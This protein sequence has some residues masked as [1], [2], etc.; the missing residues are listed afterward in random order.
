M[1]ITITEKAQKTAE[2]ERKIAARPTPKQGVISVPRL[3]LAALTREELLLFLA[4]Q[5]FD[6][7]PIHRLMYKVAFWHGLRVS[8][9][10]S[11]TKENIRDGNITVQRLKGSLA[12]VQPFVA[13]PN[14]LLNEADDLREMYSQLQAGERL[15]PWDRSWV[16]KLMQRA[17]TQVG[18]PAYKMHPHALKH[19]IAILTIR[20]AGIEHV[21]VRLGHK[22]IGSTG[23]Y[24]KATEEQASEAVTSAM[25]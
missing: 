22:S 16:R 8:E 7:N 5:W 17:G 13:H 3:R 12:T 2:R 23:E 25:L 14:P 10:I 24:L 4:W 15:F 21:R 11:L 18:I 6:E 1:T 20:K 19:T 9:L